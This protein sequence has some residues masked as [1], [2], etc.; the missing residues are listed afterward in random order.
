MS[1]TRTAAAAL[2]AAVMLA[3]AVPAAAGDGLVVKESAHSVSGTLDRLAGLLRD[4][5]LTVFTRIDHAAGADKAGLDLPP[6]QLL[7]FGNPK[8]GTPLMQDSRTAGLDLPQKALAWRDADGTVR[9]AYTDP[10]HLA[11]RHGLDESGAV[12]DRIASALDAFSDH[13]TGR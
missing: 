6:T 7:V 2:A 1:L 9:L 13:A 11:A 3:G 4:K 10:A 12:L 8:L 5:G